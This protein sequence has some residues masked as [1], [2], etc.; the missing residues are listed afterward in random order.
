MRLIWAAL[1]RYQ[2]SPA[3]CECDCSC[4]SCTRS[5][6]RRCRITTLPLWRRCIWSLTLPRRRPSPSL[7]TSAASPSLV[8]RRSVSPQC[9]SLHTCAMIL[10]LSLLPPWVPRPDLRRHRQEQQQLGGHEGVLFVLD[11]ARQEP[12]QQKARIR[13]ASPILYNISSLSGLPCP[14]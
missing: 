1:R 8:R 13:I 7:L 11:R 12:G 4:G 6:T 9:Q 2:N 5:S 3:D 10:N 14:G